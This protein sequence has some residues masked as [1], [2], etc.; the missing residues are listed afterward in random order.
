MSDSLK[1]IY[2]PILALVSVIVFYYMP[3]HHSEMKL[4]L[5]I[6]TVVEFL[7]VALSF[8]IF[9]IFWG[10][11]SKHLNIQDT[12]FML[13]FLSVGFF[14]TLHALSFKGMP[15]FVSTNGVEKAIYFWLAARIF[16]AFGFLAFTFLPHK[17]ISMKTSN[18]FLVSTFVIILIIVYM[19]IE[20]QLM[21]PRMFIEGLGLTPLKMGMEY[22]L[23]V[24]NL[25]AGIFLLFKDKTR[26][27]KLNQSRNLT[28]A[29]AALIMVTVGLC[30]TLY[31]RHNDVM[32]FWGHVLKA[33][34]YI[35]IYHAFVR[36]ELLIPYREISTI[37]SELN[38]KVENM[39]VLESELERARKIASL[40]SEVRNIAHDLNNVL[41][42]ISNAASSIQKIEN[43]KDDDR[44]SKRVVQIKQ[45]V[46]KSQDF[47]RSLMN[48]SK[49]VDSPKEIIDLK[50][51]FVDFSQLLSP[52]ILRN[53]RLSFHVAPNVQLC[54][55]R[56]DLEQVIF[57]LVLNSRDAIGD[58]FGEI[59]VD[60]R[61]VII[62]EEVKFLH[63]EI[64]KGEYIAL[65]VK[66]NGSG[67]EK[68]HIDRIFDPFFTTKKE[69]AGAGIGL[70]TVIGIMQKNNGY[71]SV[72]SIVNK[73][74]IFTLYFLR[75]QDEEKF[76][77]TEDVA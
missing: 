66:D 38:L 45:A 74:T 17:P 26:N 27:D 58:K 72:N 70:A 69:N 11:R 62:D 34:S 8:M 47:M 64:P 37:Q 54:I 43:L 57:N 40:G 25:M 7:C 67:I 29:N 20:N 30:F 76:K 56:S 33:L 19:V 36:F 23:M 59:N 60:V 44:V 48:F 35:Y 46:K 14:D 10:V 51:V 1:K 31:A 5:A 50:K 6:H 21:L 18:L 68:Q 32:N 24:L 41:M 77:N 63:Y 3:F 52:I 61:N 53:V 13:S 55:A 15:D 65:S 16:Q 49:D 12:L 4:H 39:K 2:L 71:I 28:L 75:N 42:I 73:E 22:L 9:I